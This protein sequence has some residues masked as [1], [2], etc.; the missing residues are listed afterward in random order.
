MTQGA[1]RTTRKTASKADQSFDL[2]NWLSA[3]GLV[4]TRTLTVDGV[5]FEIDRAATPEQVTAHSEARA[6]GDVLGAIAALLADEGREDD[7][8]EAFNRQ[9]QPLTGDD[10]SAYLTAILDFVLTG[11][12]EYTPKLRA[13]QA[14]E[15]ADAEDAA[16][17]S[18]AS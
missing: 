15:G 11:D 13:K 1:P 6:K 12:P 14:E 4:G 16:G 3:R 9:R 10:E 8:R 2:N 7:F 17:E 5:E 18:S